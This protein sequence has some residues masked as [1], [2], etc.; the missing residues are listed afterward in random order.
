M[1]DVVLRLWVNLS[2]KA[3]LKHAHGAAEMSVVL[4]TTLLPYPT[5]LDWILLPQHEVEETHKFSQ[6]KQH[7]IWCLFI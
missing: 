3:I 6:V 1:P 7:L 4:E 2:K 5:K